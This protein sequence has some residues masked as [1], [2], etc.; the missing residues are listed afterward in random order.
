M[1]LSVLIPVYNEEKTVEAIINKVNSLPVEKEIIVIDNCSQDCTTA[2]LRSFSLS[3][4]KVIH[5]ASKRDRAAALRTGLENAMGEFVI[6]LEAGLEYDPNDY[7][8][9]LEAARNQ[10]ADLVLGVR[11]GKGSFLTV[12]LNVL[13]GVKLHDWFSRYQV[14]RRQSLLNLA[15]RLRGEN[16]AFEILIKALR[17]KMRVLELSVSHV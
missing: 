6:I 16:P 14:V 10:G 11:A 9:F 2:I 1:I 7:L 3:N 5:H 17:K 15:P 13:F 8:K 12:I 4:L